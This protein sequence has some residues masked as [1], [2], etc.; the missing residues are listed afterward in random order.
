MLVSSVTEDCVN[1]PRKTPGEDAGARGRY[2]WMSWDW[3]VKKGVGQAFQA[4]GINVCVSHTH[5]LLRRCLR[6][7]AEDE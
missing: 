3:P 7:L 2:K 4:E 6:R 5:S 1:D